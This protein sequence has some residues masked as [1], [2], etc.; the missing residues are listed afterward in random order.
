M[1][2]S[3]ANIRRNTNSWYNRLVN[4]IN[5]SFWGRFVKH[6]RVETPVTFRSMA[7]DFDK[8]IDPQ[9]EGEIARYLSTPVQTALNPA[10]TLL[11]RMIAIHEIDPQQFALLEQDKRE[12]IYERCMQCSR[13]S[14]CW[15]A[16][17]N[18]AKAQECKLFC[19]NHTTLRTISLNQE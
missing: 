8:P 2:K 3:E 19:P 1:T 18:R 10:E 5:V 16:M 14:E 9:L 7:T 17:R 13:V 4:F 6:L 12:L 15:Q 11:P